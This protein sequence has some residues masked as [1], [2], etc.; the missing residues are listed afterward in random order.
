MAPIPLC[1]SDT[2]NY[3]PYERH[4]R[5]MNACQITLQVSHCSF[6]LMFSCFTSIRIAAIESNPIAS[7]LK[8]NTAGDIFLATYQVNRRSMESSSPATPPI[9]T[10]LR[11]FCCSGRLSSLMM[12]TLICS[13]KEANWAASFLS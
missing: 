8:E 10:G 9:L 11:V 3:I 1:Y 12:M 6:Q 4:E 13:A 7:K 5:K 2:T